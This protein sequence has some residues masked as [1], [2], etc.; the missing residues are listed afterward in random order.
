MSR[1]LQPQSFEHQDFVVG[2]QVVD[3]RFPSFSFKA[4]DNT[5]DNS[6]SAAVAL[7]QFSNVQPHST[8]DS[9][10]VTLSEDGEQRS[11]PGSQAMG[12]PAEAVAWLVRS[13][14]EEGLVLRQG[15][16]VFT[17]GLTAPF[18]GAQGK[19]YALTGH[20]LGALSL[21]FD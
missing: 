21:R 20:P 9:L 8:L 3:P 2:H 15:E 19:T 18:D 7:G 17:G 16:I 5:A 11:G 12:S 10:I 4:L 1:V 14:A 6:S 13:L